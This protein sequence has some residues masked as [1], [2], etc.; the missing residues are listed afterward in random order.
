MGKTI[1][2]HLD[3]LTEVL[4]KL[5]TVGVRLK[6]KKCEFLISEIRRIF[7]S[8]YFPRQIAANTYQSEGHN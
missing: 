5:E 3:N 1:K 6:Q 8:S 2:E 4:I 7:G